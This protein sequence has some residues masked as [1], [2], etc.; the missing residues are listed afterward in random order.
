MLPKIHILLALALSLA[1][2]TMA[3]PL[4]GTEDAVTGVDDPASSCK[5]PYVFICVDKIDLR[6][7]KKF[8]GC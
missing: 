4:A 7:G 3:A 2:V 1:H 8:G 6:C 5:D